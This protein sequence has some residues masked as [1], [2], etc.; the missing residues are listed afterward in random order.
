MHCGMPKG[1]HPTE[2]MSNSKKI[3]PVALIVTE[4]RSSE[5]ISQSVC[6]SLENYGK[7]IFLNP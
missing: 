2:T 7:Y 4:L 1:T 3:K 6:Q 5:G